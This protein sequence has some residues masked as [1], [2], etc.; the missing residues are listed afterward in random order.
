[1]RIVRPFFNPDADPWDY[2]REKLPTISIERRRN[3]FDEVEMSW[4][5]AVAVRQASRCLRCDYGK[6]K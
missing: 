3:N 5:E 6:R 4:G 2:K 1:M